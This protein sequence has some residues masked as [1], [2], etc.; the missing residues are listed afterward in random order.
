M[1][2]FL[3]FSG[4][5]EEIIRELS[6]DRE[7]HALA[8]SLDDLNQPPEQRSQPRTPTLSLLEQVQK[9]LKDEQESSEHHPQPKPKPTLGTSSLGSKAFPYRQ[10]YHGQRFNPELSYFHSPGIVSEPL[11]PLRAFPDAVNKSSFDDSES[12][13]EFGDVRYDIKVLNHVECI[14]CFGFDR[15]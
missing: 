2:L 12:E 13:M 1:G 11:K 3:D 15:K 7:P 10:S 8:Q 14:K 5:N 9:R 6:V 4:N